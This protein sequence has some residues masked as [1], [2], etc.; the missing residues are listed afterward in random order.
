MK[1]LKKEILII[2]VLFILALAGIYIANA[3]PASPLPENP[4]LK[5]AILTASN[6]TKAGHYP[7]SKPATPRQDCTESEKNCNAWAIYD[8]CVDGS[9]YCD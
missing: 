6:D 8:A 4:L 5:S 7:C 2:A 1:S 3:G 9:P